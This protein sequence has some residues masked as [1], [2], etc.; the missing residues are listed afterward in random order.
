[1]ASAIERFRKGELVIPG[2]DPKTIKRIY[3]VL[4]LERGIPQIPLI[5][6]ALREEVR[7]KTKMLEANYFEFWDIDELELA[8][9]LF[10]DRI[11]DLIEEKHQSGFGAFPL[12]NFISRKPTRYRSDYVQELWRVSGDEVQELL[13]PGQRKNG[14]A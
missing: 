6:D 10:K 3:P 9:P 1:M 13:F 8:A 5:V 4:V 2:I 11:S 14:S 7:D 12:N